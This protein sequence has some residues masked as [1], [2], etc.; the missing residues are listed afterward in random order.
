MNLSSLLVVYQLQYFSAGRAHQCPGLALTPQEHEEGQGGEEER[1]GRE[2][3]ERRGSGGEE[4][5]DEAKESEAGDVEVEGRLCKYAS[6]SSLAKASQT[7]PQARSGGE[8][9]EQGEGEQGEE[10][11]GKG[12]EREE[13]GAVRGRRSSSGAGPGGL[14][15]PAFQCN[16]CQISL[17]SQSQVAQVSHRGTAGEGSTTLK[18]Y[19]LHKLHY[20][21][22]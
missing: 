21:V 22:C 16:L 19:F 20:C 6:V 7:E 13:Q 14:Q 1:R 9:E 3:E 8:Q 4:E 12:E 15:G 5:S 18:K 17:N 2:E 10:Q 11:Q